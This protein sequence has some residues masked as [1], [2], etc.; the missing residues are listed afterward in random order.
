M[1]R[2]LSFL[3]IATLGFVLALAG[4]VELDLSLAPVVS[5][6]V[7]A[8]GLGSTDGPPYTRTW[9]ILIGSI[10]LF[11]IVRGARTAVRPQTAKR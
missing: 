6:T 3:S 7:T 11:F 9:I 2:H 10:V 4:T 1:K 5:D 8:A